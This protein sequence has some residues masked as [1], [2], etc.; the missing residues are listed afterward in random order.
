MSLLILAPSPIAAIAASRGSGAANLL[1]ADPREV[2]IDSA[3]GAATLSIDLGAVRA[4]DTVFLGFVADPADA[5]TWTITGG[6]AAHGEFV[7]QAATAMRAPDAP[8]LRAA[9]SHALWH[10]SAVEARFLRLSLSQPAGAGAL[11]AGA[12]MAGTAFRPDLGME[13]GAGRRPIDRGSV[14]PLPSGGFAIVEGARTRYFGCTLGDLSE[15]EADRLEAIGLQCGETRPVLIV[16]SAERTAGLRGRI[17]YGLFDRW[18]QYDRR[19]RRQTRWEIGIEEWGAIP[20]AT[21]GD[22]APVP[23][24]P[25]PLPPAPVFTSQPSISPA[26]GPVGTTFTADNGAANNATSYARRWLLS[27]VPGGTGATVTPGQTGSLVLEVTATGPGGSAIATSAPVAV[28]VPAPAFVEAP[29]ISPNSGRVGDTFTADDGVASNAAS[30]ARRWLLS[31]TAIGTGVTVAPMEAG[32][33]VLE[34]TA[35]GPGGAATANS[36]AV[37]IDAAPVAPISE[38]MVDG[39]Q[40]SMVA[41][42]ELA[43]APVDV[44]RQGFSATAAPIVVSETFLTTKRVRRLWPDQ[45]QVDG[46]K[47]A[48]SDA[49][50]AG[51]AVGGATI[52]STRVSPKPVAKWATIDQFV[53]GNAIGG[54]V[55]PVEILAFH[56]NGLPR[57]VKF[58]VSDG[59]NSVEAIVSAPV[60]SP[61]AWDQNGVLVYRMPETSLAGLADQAVLTVN[62]EVYPRVGV[63]ASVERS[64][65]RAAAHEFSPRHYFRHVARRTAPVYVY[66]NATTGVDATVNASGMAG[67]IQKVSADPAVAAA[68]PFATLSALT[69]AVRALTLAT[70]LTGG[71]TSG[72]IVRIQGTVPLNANFQTGTY[73]DTNGGHMI[74]ERDPNDPAATVT[75]GSNTANKRMPYVLWRDLILDRVGD[76]AMQWFYGQRVTVRNNGRTTISHTGFVELEGAAIAGVAGSSYAGSASASTRLLRG[77]RMHAGING[78]FPEPHCIIGC[79]MEDGASLMALADRYPDRGIVAFNRF[80]KVAT[81]LFGL[82]G[83]LTGYSM[84]QNLVEHAGTSTNSGVSFSRDGEPGST[85][86]VVIWNNTILGWGD[87]YR[88]NWAYTDGSG[89]GNHQRTHRNWSVRGNILPQLN[90]KTEIFVALNESNPAAAAAATGN[91]EQ[92]HGV[93][94]VGNIT[95]F[96]DAASNGVVQGSNFGR[97]YGGLKAQNGTSRTARLDPM[98]VDDRGP[99][100]ATVGGPG[101]GNYNLQPGSPAIGVLTAAEDWLPFDLAGQPRDRGSVGCYR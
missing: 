34:V 50:Y 22:G 7:I 65:D 20:V 71:R 3:T 69:G 19:N 66:V 58:I 87:N 35:T 57:A 46:A 39:W 5:A 54:D 41:P 76:L 67:T 97:D 31:G 77:V 28:T 84:V 100:S 40:A 16:E 78:S 38:G 25:P 86:H 45:A 10:G 101:G 89:N 94:W 59:V 75:Y 72:C 37:A 49:F 48:L 92:R 52:A 55:Q 26:G 15:A 88:C 93:G 29:S 74:V 79:L 73:Q 6:V 53:V 96:T 44:Q 81:G 17:H 98:F 68:N 9:V 91:W 83:T 82:S 11:S 62:A 8:G 43:L 42:A 64:A 63:S 61:N 12:L 33:L 18:R 56:R 24:P 95:M 70:G 4:V 13:W 60:K 80:M 23:P 1:T 99:T 21:I 32:S 85:D 27:G 90:M 2:W 51:D 30:I 14:T 47:V 36:A